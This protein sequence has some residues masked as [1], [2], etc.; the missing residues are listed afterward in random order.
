[1]L[2]QSTHPVRGATAAAAVHRPREN[3]SIHAPREGCDTMQ[4]DIN[5]YQPCISIH[6]PR[7]GC[8]VRAA[9]PVAVLYISIH[10]PREGCDPPT[11][12]PCTRQWVFQSTHPVRGATLATSATSGGISFQSTHPVRGATRLDIT[13]PRGQRISIHAP[14]EGC[15]VTTLAVDP[16]P[17]QFQSTHP[18]R[19]ATIVPCRLAHHGTISIH[20]PRE[21]C[22]PD[23]YTHV[24]HSA[25]SIHAPR[26]G[27]DSMDTI[28]QRPTMTFQSTHPV[29]GAT[30]NC[31][32]AT[33]LCPY[34]NP[35]TP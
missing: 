6:A 25:I 19:G 12:H 28:I 18:V 34:F 1:M 30:P 33:T 24:Q 2:F 31:R 11:D 21:G 23:G 26:E 3:I 10:A 16:V 7:E 9:L 29:R 14:R 35:R 5:H 17:V 20:A 4:N 32:W 13:R 15:D 27:C 8:D 22:D